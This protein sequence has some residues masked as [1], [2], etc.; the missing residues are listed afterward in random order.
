MCPY[1][2]TLYVHEPRL[3]AG[4]TEPAGCLVEPLQAAR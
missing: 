1:C 2:S 4:E 3:G